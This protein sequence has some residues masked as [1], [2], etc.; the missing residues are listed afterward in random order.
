MNGFDFA[1]T[2]S[3]G[4]IMH[5]RNTILSGYG[6][7]HLYGPFVSEINNMNAGR[8]IGMSALLI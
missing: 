1:W 2:A 3:A 7:Y 6:T 8:H 5:Q 4:K